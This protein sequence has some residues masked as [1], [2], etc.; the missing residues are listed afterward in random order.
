MENQ[1]KKNLS[2]NERMMGS[3]KHREIKMSKGLEALIS[4][5]SPQFA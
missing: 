2:K 4:G 3:D 5:M 1:M